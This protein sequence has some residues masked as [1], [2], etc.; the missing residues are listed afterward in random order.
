[1]CIRD[2]FPRLTSWANPPILSCRN[3]HQFLTQVLYPLGLSHTYAVNLVTYLPTEGFGCQHSLCRRR[4]R[5]QAISQVASHWD[6]S[7]FEPVSQGLPMHFRWVFSVLS[8]YWAKIPR[9]RFQLHRL[10]YRKDRD[11]LFE[12][13]IHIC[14][15]IWQ[16]P[17]L[18]TLG[19]APFGLRIHCDSM[20][21]KTEIL[22]SLVQLTTNPGPISLA[23]MIANNAISATWMKTHF[24]PGSHLGTSHGFYIFST[25]HLIMT[26]TNMPTLWSWIRC[27]FYC[28]RLYFSV[29]SYG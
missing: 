14:D 27:L 13:N 2:S 25:N 17:S 19:K 16:N 24:Q 11:L 22:Q 3:D 9:A 15:P 7:R 8:A 21:M 6:R 23:L 29:S 12:H 10:A 28:S 5:R 1:M 18:D 4:E 20:K 26:N